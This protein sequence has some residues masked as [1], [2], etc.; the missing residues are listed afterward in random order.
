M[1]L[2]C[3]TKF[4]W[5]IFK[6]KITS[7]F[8]PNGSIETLFFVIDINK[9]HFNSNYALTV[10]L[11]VTVLLN[12]TVLFLVAKNCD[13]YNKYDS[14]NELNPLVALEFRKTSKW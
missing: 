10:C 3:R 1:A 4:D 8:R 14:E 12:V 11:K 7:L 6:L 9:R 2:Q 5:R 13:Y